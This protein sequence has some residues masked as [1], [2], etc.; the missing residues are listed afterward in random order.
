MISDHMTTGKN[1]NRFQLRR[2]VLLRFLADAGSFSNNQP[3]QSGV[4][5][6]YAA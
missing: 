4:A 1:A 5:T 2:N 6:V 3:Y